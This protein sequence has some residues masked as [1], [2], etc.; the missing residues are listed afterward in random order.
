MKTHL[1]A[2]PSSSISTKD[3]L[4]K[5]LQSLASAKDLATALSLFEAAPSSII[6]SYVVS[7]VVN[8]AVRSGDAGTALKVVEGEVTR[9]KGGDKRGQNFLSTV[10]LTS[11][12]K[13]FA[14][15]SE[16]FTSI[17]KN[18]ETIGAGLL[19]LKTMLSP[20]S[21][22][23]F[24]CYP[25][26]RTL[27]TFLRGCLWGSGGCGGV[28]EAVE[29]WR[30]CMKSEEKRRKKGG[31]C[32]GSKGSSGGSDGASSLF[33]TSS[34]GYMVDILLRSFKISKAEEMLN[35]ASSVLSLEDMSSI[36]MKTTWTKFR[37]GKLK[38]N[39]LGF[40]VNGLDTTEIETDISEI[41]E[42]WRIESDGSAGRGN[43]P[44]DEDANDISRKKSNSLY[45]KHACSYMK[46]ELDRLKSI[47]RDREASKS[48]YSKNELF[49][50][51]GR[52]VFYFGGGGTTDSSSSGVRVVDNNGNGSSSGS[53]SGSGSGSDNCSNSGIGNNQNIHKSVNLTINLPDVK[54]QLFTSLIDNFGFRT[55]S[56]TAQTLNPYDPLF[57]AN[58][59][60]L[61]FGEI[62]SQNR[63][64]SL[65][66]LRIEIGSGNGD[67]VI[68]QCRSSPSPANFL[69]IE[70]RSDRI[71][72][73]IEK[74]A[75][76]GID[77]LC[78][79]GGECGKVLRDF[80]G[81][82]SVECVYVNFPEPPQQRSGDK[83][84]SAGHMLKNENL[85]IIG[86]SLLGDGRGRFIF[87]SDN[88]SFTRMIARELC[89]LMCRGNKIKM[90]DDGDRVDTSESGGLSQLE[91]VRGRE[92]REVNIFAG[93]PN[94]SV[95]WHGSSA[96]S[97]SYF[98]GLW[99]SGAGANSSSTDRFVIAMRSETSAIRPVK[100]NSNGSYVSKK[101]RQREVNTSTDDIT[102]AND[103][104]HERNP[105]KQKNKKKKNKKRSPAA[106]EARNKRR[107][108]SKQSLE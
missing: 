86:R 47:M 41:E 93:N 91:V 104:D 40:N 49:D 54:D 107:L 95:G 62:F 80:V 52:R 20:T 37:I 17:N 45:R 99:Q 73:Q 101:K 53:G 105:K 94:A 98:D 83:D 13:G 23:G 102:K 22:Y 71:A 21:R 90:V 30:M 43:I 77:N 5:T 29:G 33:D 96:N 56:S 106:Q 15:S 92:S 24:N 108:S 67:W 32:R 28:K 35:S 36:E 26:C 82:K 68:N 81:E 61:K 85:E 44:G 59:N 75:L 72:K 25:N 65:H 16:T 55:S 76:G 3:E 19:L 87:V 11:L 70:L 84:E 31:K 66:P 8:C 39:L 4:T 27:N 18:G 1:I 64:D 2:A 57:D 48:R 14:H 50:L 12:M 34:F 78:V 9:A 60:K 7:I 103:D 100:T 89:N 42:Y 88:L 97:T 6:D 74:M 51:M 69:S 46:S 58:T 63:K 10:A 79:A 38:A